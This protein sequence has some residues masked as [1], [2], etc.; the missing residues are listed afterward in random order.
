MN[1]R[2]LML[3]LAMLCVMESHY[4]GSTFDAFP[5][6]NGIPDDL[7]EYKENIDKTMKLNFWKVCDEMVARVD[8]APGPETN[9]FLIAYTTPRKEDMFWGDTVYLNEYIH[10]V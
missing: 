2:G 4:L 1:H 9:D 6:E 5:N 7:E 3:P 10:R 8:D